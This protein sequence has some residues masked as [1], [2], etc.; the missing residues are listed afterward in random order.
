M[1]PT[2]RFRWLQYDCKDTKNAQRPAHCTNGRGTCW[3]LQQWHETYSDTFNST[4]EWL[5]LPV[6]REEI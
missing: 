6:T 5:E 2:W 3:V 1:I 4:G